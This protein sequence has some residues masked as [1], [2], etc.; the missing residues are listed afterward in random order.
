MLAAQ[1]HGDSGFSQDP[2]LGSQHCCTAII[3]VDVLGC[4]YHRRPERIGCTELAQAL[5]GS[6]ATGEL[7][8]PFPAAALGRTDPAPQLDSTGDLALVV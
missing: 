1:S 2:S 5:T 3:C 7:V 4:C 6:N 8:L